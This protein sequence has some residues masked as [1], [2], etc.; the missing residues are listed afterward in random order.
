MN[1]RT[2]G[3]QMIDGHTGEAFS[4]SAKAMPPV[5]VSSFTAAGMTL[6]QWV[7]VATLIYT[8][9]QAA[10]LVYKFV[11]DRRREAAGDPDHD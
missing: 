3:T 11:R 9:L 2:L 6:E 4:A 5:A 7:L 1:A 8:V 10:H